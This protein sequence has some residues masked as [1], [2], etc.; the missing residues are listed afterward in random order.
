MFGDAIYEVM[1][2]YGGRIFT[3]TEHLARLSRSLNEVKISPPM[4][5]SQWSL[6]LREAVQRSGERDAL[7]YVQ[8]TRGVAP[9]RSHVYPNT[10]P[11]VLVTVTPFKPLAREA[12]VPLSVKT[13]LDFRWQRADIKVTSLIANGMI[14]NEA[15]AEGYDDAVMIRDGKVT[16]GTASNVF[17]VV[18]DEIRTPPKSWQLLHGITRAEMIDT[19]RGCGMEVVETIIDEAELYEAHELWLSSTGLELAPVGRVNDQL[20]GD[21][22]AGPIWHQM[23]EAFQKRKQTID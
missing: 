17:I 22:K 11:T 16:E 10:N 5:E 7:I 3:E 18:G 2:V 6:L 23:F 15:L 14:K 13:A 20:I 8:V 21:G 19:A 9:T 12:V 4:T 1:P